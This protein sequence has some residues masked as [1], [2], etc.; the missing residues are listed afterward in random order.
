M[1]DKRRMEKL[2]QMAGVWMFGLAFTGL[3]LEKEVSLVTKQP[4]GELA[5][6]GRLSIDLHA[7]FMVSRSYGSET[8][9]NWYNC[10][11]SGGG[12]K[13]GKVT[14]VG[15]TFGDFG[16]Q[17]PYKDREEK[18]P[19]AVT[20][21]AVRAVRFDGN[22]F[23]KGNFEVEPA[24]AGA[25]NMT[26]EIWFRSDK[27]E[28]NEILLGWQSRDGRESSAAIGYPESIKGSDGWR[29]LLIT[30]TPASES[31]YLDGIKVSS[32]KRTT[33]I[34]EGHILVLGGASESKPS[35]KGDL[36]AVRL[37]D[38]SMTDE[39]IAHNA[40]GGVMLGTALQNWWRTEPDK[41][42]IKESERFRYG[43]A[44]EKTAAREKD[45]RALK[46]FNERV[47][48]MFNMA[49]VIYENQTNGA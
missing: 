11:Y 41:W 22:D 15:G 25:Q 27:P 38:A 30:C 37:H 44:K 9:L 32:G 40:K 19:H 1:N 35:F 34:K 2:V 3:A 4:L 46:E 10:G 43:E 23:L 49:E 28:K 31:W 7:E 14:Q 16:F 26:L 18:Y 8:V 42:T 36:A 6:A 17:V 21:G 20:V 13:D 12:G 47:P 33:L 39:E 29:H 24:L 48:N 5:V 45:A